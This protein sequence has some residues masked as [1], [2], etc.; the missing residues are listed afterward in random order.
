MAEQKEQNAIRV[1]GN[2]VVYSIP[3]EQTKLTIFTNMGITPGGE[4]IGAIDIRGTLGGKPFSVRATALYDPVRLPDGVSAESE[5]NHASINGELG[6]ARVKWFSAGLI[7]VA[8][9]TD[10][11]DLVFVVEAAS[12]IL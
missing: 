3:S 12:R 6:T 7:Q 10:T 2:R 11:R 8:L 4:Q 9:H 5:E 1:A